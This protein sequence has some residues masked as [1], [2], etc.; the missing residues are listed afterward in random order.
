M[1]SI[2][3]SCIR[4]EQRLARCPVFDSDPRQRTLQVST[5]HEIANPAALGLFGFGITTALLQG[6]VTG[7]SGA[8][9]MS[10]AIAFALGFGGT[11]QVVAGIID[12]RRNN[13]FGGTAFLTYGCFWWSVA[14]YDVL[15]RLPSYEV[16]EAV[17]DVSRDGKA[18]MLKQAIMG[19]LTIVLA[20]C[21][22]NMNLVMVLLFWM[23]ALLFFFLCGGVYNNTMEKFAGWW[24]LCVAAVAIYAAAAQLI[25]D[26]Y[27]RQVLPIVALRRNK[28]SHAGGDVEAPCDLVDLHTA[29]WKDE[30]AVAAH[31]LRAAFAVSHTMACN[32]CQSLGHL[33]HSAVAHIGSEPCSQGGHCCK[34]CN[35]T[36][37]LAHMKCAGSPHGSLDIADSPHEVPA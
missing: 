3:R 7:I 31:G 30:S 12:F 14:A 26:T 6:A 4:L 24:G 17:L 35:A 25:N 1:E 29:R 37:P 36:D 8:A 33:D 13:M 2:E 32:H 10:W 28:E 19:V 18:M 34:A 15:T 21:T 5:R 16:A 20:L 22:F 27:H 9:T 11:A 23:L